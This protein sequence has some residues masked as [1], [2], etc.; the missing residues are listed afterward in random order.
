MRF[1]G[2][3][4]DESREEVIARKGVPAMER[5]TMVGA[6]GLV[7]HERG[8]DGLVRLGAPVEGWGASRLRSEAEQPLGDEGCIGVGGAQWS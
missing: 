8:S 4:P 3:R 5:D 2:R 7:M 6:V 1:A